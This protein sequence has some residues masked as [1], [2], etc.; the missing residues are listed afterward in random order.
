MTGSSASS[1]T[2]S[3]AQ[4]GRFLV[5]GLANT[6]ISLGVYRLLLAL[7]TPYGD[8]ATVLPN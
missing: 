3:L 7:N 1:G 5:V 8:L 6:A 4:F 2:K